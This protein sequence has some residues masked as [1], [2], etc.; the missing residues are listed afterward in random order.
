MRVLDASGHGSADSQAPDSAPLAERA[1]RLLLRAYPAAFQAEY[2][3]EMLLHFR[4]LRRAAAPARAALD[5][6]G[7]VLWDVVRSAPALRAQ[8]WRARALTLFRRGAQRRAPVH[9]RWLDT[10]F[11]GGSTMRAA[12]ATAGLAVVVGIYE[13]ANALAEGWAGRAAS[14]GGTT[15]GVT[16]AGATWLMAL[17]L[18]A[19]AGALLAAVGVALLRRRPAGPLPGWLRVATVGCLVAFVAAGF[20]HS[21]MALVA[22]LLGVAVPLAL[23]AV[24]RPGRGPSRPAAA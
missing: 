2:G 5:F 16:G 21:W 14:A 24:L 20:V 6:W 19:A 4:D 8:D 1:Y 18:A 22:R 23:L 17:A 11:T 13:G 10:F 9:G 7:D 12:R 15:D 3:R